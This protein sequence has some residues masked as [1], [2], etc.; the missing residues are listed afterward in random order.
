MK[1]LSRFMEHFWLAVTIATTL[2]ATYM[3]VTSG[4]S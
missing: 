3:V 1:K 4:L 2:W